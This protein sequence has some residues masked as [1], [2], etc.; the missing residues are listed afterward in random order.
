MLTIVTAQECSCYMFLIKKKHNFSHTG[1]ILER[2]LRLHFLSTSFKFVCSSIKYLMLCPSTLPKSELL[3]LVKSY[4]KWH[5]SWI[6][7]YPYK[8]RFKYSKL[9]DFLVSFFFFFLNS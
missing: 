4:L 6:L 7:V 3:L 8:T 5:S 2:N 9:H 1:L